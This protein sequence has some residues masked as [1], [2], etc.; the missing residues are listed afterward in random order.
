MPCLYEKH[1]YKSKYSKPNINMYSIYIHV[2]IILI[3]EN[4]WRR[5]YFSVDFSRTIRQ[6]EQLIR[7]SG[8]K[9]SGRGCP[10]RPLAGG[11]TLAS[12]RTT[13]FRC[14]LIKG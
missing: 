3:V 13:K 10:R 5:C 8:L 14:I 11:P 1:T 7:S 4:I 12:G 2:L 6:W 9:V